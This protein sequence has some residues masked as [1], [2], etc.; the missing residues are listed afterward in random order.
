MD[1]LSILIVEDNQGDLVLIREYLAE[2][3]TCPYDLMAAGTLK[4]AL[5]LLAQHDFDL[6]LLDL[7][8]P[9]SFGLDTVRRVITSYPDIAVIVL[10]GLQDEDMA[11]QSVR[12]GAQDYLEKQYLSPVMLSKSIRYSMERKRSVQE[13]DDLLHDL[14]QALKKIES[15]E[16]ILPMCVSCKKILDENHHWQRMED[17]IRQSCSAEVL[18]LVCPA[19]RTELEKDAAD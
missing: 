11:L 8:L 1:K 18:H 17:Y 9:D 16:G 6:V 4:S 5:D 15:L 2:Q 10:T 7:S 19:C 13:K 12:Y 14:T 3:Q